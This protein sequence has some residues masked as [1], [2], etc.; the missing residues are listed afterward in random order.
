MINDD[1]QNQN[2][3]DKSTNI[4]AKNIILNQGI[5]YE[6]AKKIALDIY[7]ENFLKLKN[8]AANIARERAEE[9]TNNFLNKLSETAPDKL[10]KMSNPAMQAALYTAQKEFAI[11][12]EKDIE[13]VLVDILVDRTNENDRS[14]RQIVL[15]ESLSTIGK[16][17]PQ[18]LDA[19]TLN[20]LI[21]RTKAL[22]IVNIASLQKHFEDE[23]FRFSDNLTQKASSYEHLVYAGCGTISIG[24]W[25]SIHN[26]YKKQYPGLF[27]KG[28]TI[29]E[30]ESKN[31]HNV[32][33]LIMACFH[34]F[35][36]K[37]FKAM[38]GDV[39]TKQ[40][41]ACNVGMD[42]TKLIIDFFNSYILSDEEIKH[43]LLELHPDKMEKLFNAWE[44]SSI[45]KFNLTSVGIALAQANYK[46]KTGKKID[47]SIW[48]NE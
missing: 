17:T 13:Q 8:E 11:S 35:E 41:I 29:E 45:S 25:G 47:L 6:D 34:D 9:L 44:K 12:G 26:R 2:S 46:S 27:Q 10:N 14:L 22:T 28:F 37:Q 42:E 48:V 16:L 31:I 15:D 21:N 39:L 18:Q 3:G 23:I 33:N 7:S 43:I 20:F 36:K 40:A 30:L 4:Q 1:I 38:D 24:S 5:S 19:L 32:E